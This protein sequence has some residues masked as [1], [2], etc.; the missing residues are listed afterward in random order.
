MEI[1]A[2]GLAAAIRTKNKEFEQAKVHF[3]DILRLN[4]DLSHEYFNR[5]MC[6]YWTGDLSSA[7]R[8]MKSFVSKTNREIDSEEVAQALDII[9]QF[10]GQPVPTGNSSNSSAGFGEDG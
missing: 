8:D 10:Q 1:Q 7:A 4:P 2:H 3:T 5:G 6:H 9:S